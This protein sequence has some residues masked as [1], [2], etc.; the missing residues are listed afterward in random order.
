[1]HKNIPDIYSSLQQIAWL[2]GGH[3]IN[4]ECC[5]DL[6]FVDFIALKKVYENTAI[7]IQGIGNALN[8]TKS[9]ATRIINRLEIKGYVTR[10]NSPEDGRVCCVMITEKGVTVVSKI[11]KNYTEYL[12]ETLKNLD[13]EAVEQVKKV[14]DTLLA[15]LNKNKQCISDPL[16]VLEGECI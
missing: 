1:M 14:L 11:I 2:F 6:S 15:E 7:T 9:G 8:F 13:T 3:G 12:H 5:G 16:T 10:E 4:G